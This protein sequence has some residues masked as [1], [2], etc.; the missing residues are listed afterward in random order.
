MRRLEAQ[1]IQTRML[2]AGNLIRQPAMTQLAHD[3][4][5][6][7]RPAPFRVVGSLA[8]TDAVMNRAFWIGVYPGLSEAMRDHVVR[9]I[10]EVVRR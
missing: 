10:R 8:S 1:K 5:A 4:R 3:A 9:T 6:A 7:G 2:F